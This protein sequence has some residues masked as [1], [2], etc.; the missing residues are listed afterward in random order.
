MVFIPFQLQ[1][2]KNKTFHCKKKKKK[3]RNHVFH[4]LLAWSR[5]SHGNRV[6]RVLVKR[7]R[8]LLKPHRLMACW[9]QRSAPAGCNSE[10]VNSVDAFFIQTT[11]TRLV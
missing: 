3:I 5:H 2:K 10:E 7:E 1:K 11:S 9:R 4:K 8:A 6:H